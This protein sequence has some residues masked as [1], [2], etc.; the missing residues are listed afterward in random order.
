M[1]E[2]T[3]GLE[4]LLRSMRER[5]QARWFIRPVDPVADGVPQYL[6][7]I[8]EPMDLRTI[9]RRLEK[10]DY[11]A[12]REAFARDVRLVFSNA[13][14]FNA[15][16]RSPVRA[17][18][19]GLSAFFEKKW[20]ALHEKKKKASPAAAPAVVHNEKRNRKKAAEESVSGL[21]DEDESEN[22]D[23][24]DDDHGAFTKKTKGGRKQ[25]EQ[26]NKR[27][28]KTSS[29]PKKSKKSELPKF[30]VSSASK[31]VLQVVAQPQ[32]YHFNEP[33]DAVALG[34][35]TYHEII[36]EPMDLSTIREKIKTTYKTYE[37][38]VRDVR[39]VFDNAITFNAD[40]TNPVHRDAVALSDIF[41]AKFKAVLGV[42][43]PPIRGAEDESAFRKKQQQKK[44]RGATGAFSN[45]K[46]SSVVVKKKKKNNSPPRNNNND[47]ASHDAPQVSFH[48]K[49][50]NVLERVGSRPEAYFFMQPVDP[51]ALGIPDYPKI[52]TRPM[53]LGTMAAKLSQYPDVAAFKKDADLV[54]SNAMVYNSNPKHPVHEAALKLRRAFETTLADYFSEEERRLEE[55]IIK[56]RGLA[57][58]LERITDE[59]IASEASYFFR[60]PVDPVAMGCPDYP[61]IIKQ[62]MDLATLR[63]KIPT[64]AT[65]AAFAKDANLVFYN[66]KTY[67]PDQKHD[68]HVMADDLE[69]NFDDLYTAAFPDGVYDAE[70][71]D[72]EEDQKKNKPQETTTIKKTSLDDE[73]PQEEAAK[74]SG[75]D[76]PVVV[77]G[78]GAE[79]EEEE[80]KEDDESVDPSLLLTMKQIL[81]FVQRQAHADLFAAPVDP[82]A[83]N[84]PDYLTVVK[85][86]MDFGTI[87]K[88]LLRY[89]SLEDFVA[90]IKL[91]YQNARRYN[92]S[93]THFVHQVATESA[94]ALEK[95]L[96]NMGV[97]STPQMS[98]EDKMRQILD[99]VVAKKDLSFYFTEPVDPEKLGLHDY[100]DVIEEPMDLG[101]VRKKLSSS[102]GFEAFNADV[103]LVFQNAMKYNKDPKLAVHDAAKRLLN[104]FD[105]KM[106]NILKRTK[107]KTSLGGGGPSR[108]RPLSNHKTPLSST[109]TA[110]PSSPSVDN[111]HDALPLEKK[112]IEEAPAKAEE[113]VPQP[114]KRRRVVVENLFAADNSDDDD[115]EMHTNEEA[116]EPPGSA[117]SQQPSSSKTKAKI[118]SSKE[119]AAA[120]PK[121]TKAT[122]L[123]AH[124]R[125]SKVSEKT[126]APPRP[127]AP[128]RPP[129]V[130]FF[131]AFLPK[132]DG[133][134]AVDI[135]L[136]ET[137]EELETAIGA[138]D[139]SHWDNYK[140]VDLSDDIPDLLEPDLNA[141]EVHKELWR[142]GIEKALEERKKLQMEEDKKAQRIADKEEQDRQY[143]LQHLLVCQ[144]KKTGAKKRSAWSS[145]SGAST[146]KPKKP[147]ASRTNASR[148]WMQTRAEPP[149][150]R[151]NDETAPASPRPS[152]S[153]KVV[154]R[155]TTSYRPTV[156]ILFSLLT[157]P[158]GGG[159]GADFD[160]IT[161]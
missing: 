113:S 21:D 64:Y 47:E 23:S 147:S 122:K 66:A 2:G 101:T 140:D 15:D 130:D 67:N 155:S 102:Y 6:E 8:R 83:L 48:A 69:A 115:D 142:Q 112:D 12:D 154:S 24:D 54:S 76:G 9:N 126:Q 29:P 31:I 158:L 94:K 103:R 78:G 18:A 119:I 37:D 121:G 56:N 16:D 99:A 11:D 86:P 152:T 44:K 153:T 161:D 87:R 104:F 110:R 160:D 139:F 72:D 40:V 27:K 73:K 35:P 117:R 100:L 138:C 74:G 45:E 141:P 38:L 59:L 124:M 123:P 148:R 79:K 136:P 32:A 51:V 95:E 88:K 143:V 26:T 132:D 62:P 65:P 84:A 39:L 91:V 109:T 41:D 20:A 96:K 80:R 50:K 17:D 49:L 68:I 25:R 135:F 127:K 106:A 55:P 81:S 14:R 156:R 58:K 75:E 10:G 90:D 22:S 63:S 7:V 128:V 19:L 105:S 120:A 118:A 89:A 97:S 1:P 3:R 57:A 36:S 77:L 134:E 46:D 111:N 145:S 60:V 5:K 129:P 114:P 61:D 125:I 13:L 30:E 42:A 43:P 93:A 82:V 137:S 34:I 107:K 98:D 146:K 116:Y 144:K 92:K 157:L 108:K 131:A 159:S 4:S 53:D 71:E 52:V 149:T 33:V 70:A 85:K 28:K 133:V 151:K 150:A